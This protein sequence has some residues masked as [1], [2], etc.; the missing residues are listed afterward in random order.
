MNPNSGINNGVWSYW[1]RTD[2]LC[3]L[4]WCQRSSKQSQGY[5]C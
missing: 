3:S 4:G 1:S 5:K 2:G